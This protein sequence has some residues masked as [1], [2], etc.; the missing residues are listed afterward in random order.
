MAVKQKQET[1]DVDFLGQTAALE[2]LISRT[3]SSERNQPTSLTNK[4]RRKKIRILDSVLH[5]SLRHL[6]LY[7]PFSE[8]KDAAQI[9]HLLSVR[10]FIAYI[11]PLK[12]FCESADVLLFYS[13]LPIP[14]LLYLRKV[15]RHFG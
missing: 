1:N 4:R 6:K 2:Y 13:V 9:S 8:I 15:A 14:R 7:R 10:L 5:S 11:S 3:V 12:S